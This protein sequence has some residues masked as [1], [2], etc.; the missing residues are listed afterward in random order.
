LRIVFDIRGLPGAA[1]ALVSGATETP[2]HWIDFTNEVLPT[3]E[4]LQT[5]GAAGFQPDGT[6]EEA[7]CPP[8]EK[9]HIDYT[10]DL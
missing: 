10:S 8:S 6:P 9:K 2:A 3:V 7:P 1:T 4:W 5:P